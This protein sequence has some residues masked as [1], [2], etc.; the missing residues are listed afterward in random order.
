MGRVLAFMHDSLD[1]ISNTYKPDMPVHACDLSALEVEARSE[2][3]VI[4]SHMANL[5][6][7]WIT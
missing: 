5:R 4:L 3:Q 7:I 6:P 2:I 1:S